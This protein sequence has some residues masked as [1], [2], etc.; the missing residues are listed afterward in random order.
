M[1]LPEL[2]YPALALPLCAASIRGFARFAERGGLLRFFCALVLCAF[3]IDAGY[4]L[5]DLLARSSQ[6]LLAPLLG[7]VGALFLGSRVRRGLQPR[8]PAG[9]ARGGD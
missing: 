7:V 3:G 4:V 2:L 6:P 9:L 5:W 8:D 1:S